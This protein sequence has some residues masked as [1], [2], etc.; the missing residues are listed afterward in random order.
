MDKLKRPAVEASNLRNGQGGYVIHEGKRMGGYRDARGKLWLVDTTC[1]HL[2]CQ[3]SWNQ[4]RTLL[5]LPLPR[6]PLRLHR[7]TA[8]QPPLKH[9]WKEVSPP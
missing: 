5:G 3:L 9:R 4:D 8:G 2:K 7:Q 6:L 1:P